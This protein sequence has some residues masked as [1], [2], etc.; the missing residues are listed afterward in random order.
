[1][2]GAHLIGVAIESCG[3]NYDILPPPF[4]RLAGVA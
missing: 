3:P 4:R 1:M 2:G